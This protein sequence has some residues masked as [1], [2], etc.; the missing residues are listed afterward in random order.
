MRP[1]PASTIDEVSILPRDPGFCRIR[2]GRKRFGP[3]RRDDAERL[4]LAPGRSWS[5]GLESRVTALVAVAEARRAALASLARAPASRERLEARL[6]RRRHD[7]AAIRDALDQLDA[8]GWLDEAGS[9]NVRA[10]SMA[11]AHGGAVARGALEARLEDEGY[12]RDAGRA[13][14]DALGDA[15]DLERAIQ[16]ATRATS[17]APSRKRSP[18]A[19]ARD[20]ARRGFDSD[21]IETALRRTGVRLDDL[22]RR[23][24]E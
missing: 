12:R 17:K 11:R 24:D 20:L 9:A 21:T 19:L 5:R 16:A 7:A 1:M 15:S 2:V 4:G 18:A 10:R 13:A 3:L 14:R 8:D 22:D 6:E 23:A